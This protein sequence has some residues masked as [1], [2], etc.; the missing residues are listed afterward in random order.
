MKRDRKSKQ[1]EVDKQ[2]MITV[3]GG[4]LICPNLTLE[5]GL[6]HYRLMRNAG[7]PTE[8]KLLFFW[9]F[10]LRSL[11]PS[12]ILVLVTTN[13]SS[14][15]ISMKGTPL[16]GVHRSY[17]KMTTCMANFLTWL[18]STVFSTHENREIM[19]YYQHHGLNWRLSA[20]D[21]GLA[22]WRILS[23]FITII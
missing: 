20:I 10:F 8:Q 12:D 6:G 3:I 2:W 15:T 5:V 22:R 18:K 4:R 17:I 21:W 14:V 1:A 13:F 19:S 11:R 7:V 9:P 16:S 23:L